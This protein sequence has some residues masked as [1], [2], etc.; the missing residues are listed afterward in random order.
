[1]MKLARGKLQNKSKSAIFDFDREK[2][3]EICSKHGISLAVLYGSRV[4]GKETSESDV[5]IA[6]LGV[7]K[8]PPETLVELN[9]NFS[10]LF[11]ISEIDIKSLHG[12]DPLFRWEVM[13]NGA[14]FFGNPRKYADFRA[15]A[16]RDYCDSR[17]LFK[18]REILI[19]KR[20]KTLSV[21]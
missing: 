9:N 14:L 18:L 6:V 15:Y 3:S 8:I 17:G 19:E 12:A 5:D 16:F 21:N 11:R 1:M 20:L 10:D 13:K 7:D 4:R 2:M